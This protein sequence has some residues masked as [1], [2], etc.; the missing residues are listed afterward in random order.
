MIHCLGDLCDLGQPINGQMD[1]GPH[2][3]NDRREF[4]EV[5][6]FR[7]SQWIRFE[8]RDDRAGEV[9][10]PVDLI[11]EQVFPMV[12]VP[13]IAI[14]LA[15]PEVILDQLKNLHAPLSLHD[16][17]DWLQLPSQP[18]SAIPLDWTAEAAFP[19]DEADD[20][21][22]DTWPFL[23]IFRTRRIVTAH[24]PTIPGGSD[25][26]GTAGCSDVP[27]YSQLHFTPSPA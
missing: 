21:L 10:Q 13:P 1:F 3:L 14:D 7:R 18:H 6:G 11:R 25:M 4:P 20:P 15:A 9:G 19:V 17:E 16:R 26:P 24:V 8:E 27:A 2:Q 22:L 5:I 12:V 23:L